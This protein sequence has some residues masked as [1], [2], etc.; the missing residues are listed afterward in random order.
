M[1]VKKTKMGNFK[2][3]ED[4]LLSLKELSAHTKMKAKFKVTFEVADN[5]LVL[6]VREGSP[7]RLEEDVRARPLSS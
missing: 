3:M 2:Q 4:V 7:A 5:T 6:T 1:T